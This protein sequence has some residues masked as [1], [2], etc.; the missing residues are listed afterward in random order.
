MEMRDIRRIH[1]FFADKLGLIFIEISEMTVAASA[2]A[3]FP[4]QHQD[5]GRWIGDRFDFMDAHMAISSR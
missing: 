5:V 3:D 1:I 4:S 2:V